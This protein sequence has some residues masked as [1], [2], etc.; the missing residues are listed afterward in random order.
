MKVK[1]SLSISNGKVTSASARP[2]NTSTPVG[3]CV[4]EAV[5][6]AKF[7][8]AKATKITEETLTL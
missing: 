5:K 4:V 3:K 7:A 6:T 2:P 8:K 1:V